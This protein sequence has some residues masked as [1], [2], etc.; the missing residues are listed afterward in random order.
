MA[1]DMNAV[2]RLSRV[3]VEEHASRLLRVAEHQLGVRLEPPIDIELIADNHLRLQIVYEDLLSRYANPDLHGG[4]HIPEKRIVVEETLSPGRINFTVGHEVGHW[5]LHRHLFQFTNSE[6][7]LLLGMEHAASA[8]RA[9][10]LLC[11][12]NDKAWGE[13]QADWFAAALL[14]PAKSVK[15]AFDRNFSAPQTFSRDVLRPPRKGYLP[16]DRSREW[17]FLDECWEVLNVVDKVLETGNFT[18]VSKKAVRVRLE[19]LNL[20]VPES[21]QARML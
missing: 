6:R 19:T 20:I 12:T 3:Q 1:I 21:S 7:G 10:L 11:R 17:D 9:D 15:L 16:D 4:L 8:P 14:M 5:I 13:R 2:P 18:N